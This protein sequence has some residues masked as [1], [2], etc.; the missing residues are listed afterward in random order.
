MITIQMYKS[1]SILRSISFLD[2]D[3]E[4]MPQVWAFKMD[5]IA[6]MRR[7]RLRREQ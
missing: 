3:R 5:R 2:L 1:V 7:N 6:Q 4:V